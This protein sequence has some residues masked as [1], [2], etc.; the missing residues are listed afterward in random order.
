MQSRIKGN[1]VKEHLSF[2]FDPLLIHLCIEPLNKGHPCTIF[3]VPAYPLYDCCLI[4]LSLS[5]Y[6]CIVP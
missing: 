6:V 4:V 3:M 5:I 2:C 1:C